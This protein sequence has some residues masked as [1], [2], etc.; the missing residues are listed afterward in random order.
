MDNTA[1]SAA[2]PNDEDDAPISLLR[3]WRQVAMRLEPVTTPRGLLARGGALRGRC[4][5]GECRRRIDVDLDAWIAQGRGDTELRA[6][7]PAYRCG[8]LECDVR[9]DPEYFAR[10]VPLQ[11]FTGC[12]ERIEL[13]CA[14]CSRLHILTAEQLIA[15]LVRRGTG[16]GNTGVIE[17]AVRIGSPC[18]SCGKQNWKVA[19]RRPPASGTPG[20]TA[21]VRSHHDLASS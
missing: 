17:L 3:G 13:L 5:T 7:L 6:L 2:R 8:K 10:G 15:A 20:Y 4:E 14:S 1:P 11:S 21:R 19:L 9:F 12:E 16:D 18:R